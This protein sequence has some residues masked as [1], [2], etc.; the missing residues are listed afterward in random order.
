MKLLLNIY[1]LIFVFHCGTLFSLAKII[2]TKYGKI[3]GIKKNFYD[4]SVYEYLGVPFAKPPIGGLRFRT[5]VPLDEPAWTGV[6]KADKP[7]NACI[8]PIVKRG[9][10]GVG[11]IIEEEKQSEDC[12]QLNMWVPENPKGNVLVFIFGGSFRYGSPS[13]DIYNGSMIAYKTKQ[14]VVALNYRL[15]VL[16]FGYMCCGT[17]M[18]GNMGLL[19]QQLGLKWVYEN[20]KHFGGSNKQITLWGQGA[21]SVSASAHLFSDESSK[22][23]RRIILSSGTIFNN[24]GTTVRTSID[25]IIREIGIKFNCI[26]Q[27]NKIYKCLLSKDARD[28]M[29]AYEERIAHINV[30]YGRYGIGIITNDTVFFKGDVNDKIK[31]K[32]M[33]YSVDI[34]IG[35]TSNEA[36][37]FMPILRD[38]NKYGCEKTLTEPVKFTEKTCHLKSKKHLEM[39]IDSL[40]YPL[41]WN[42]SVVNVVKKTYM[43][44]G[45]KINYRN[46]ATALLSDVSFNCEIVNFASFCS[47]FS[48]GRIYFYRF[49]IKS[50]YH[51][52][53]D[54]MNT[55]HGL[56]LEY[57]FGLPFRYGEKYNKNSLTK[58]KMFSKYFMDII[59]K[60][61]L[62]GSTGSLW[63]QFTINRR[64][65]GILDFK[66]K[67][68][69]PVGH[70]S[71]INT[72]NCKT[73]GKYIPRNL[74]TL[75]NHKVTEYLGIPYARPPIGSLRFK[76]P[77]PL[78][79]FAW[80]STFNAIRPATSC[81][82]N[83]E[84][85]GFEGYDI[86][87][88]R[89][90]ISEDCLQFN[91]WVP[92]RPS[93]D[94]IVFIHGGSFIMGSG[95][96]DIYNG[97]VLAVKTRAI[98]V[99][100]NY[101]LG[102]FGFLYLP[103]HGISGN[104][105]LKDQQLGLKWIFEN[106]RYFGGH[107]K[108]ITL[109]GQS[110]GATSVTA[111]LFA[112]SSTRYIRRVIASSGTIGNMWGA[113]S[114]R[115]VKHASTEFCSKIDCDIETT[116]DVLHCLQRKA[117][118]IVYQTAEGLD[119]SLS[120]PLTH[121]FTVI[122][123]DNVFFKGNVKEKIK[124][125]KM[126]NNIDLLIGKMRDESTIYMP[127]I[128]DD[129]VFGCQF[130]HVYDKNSEKNACKMNRQNFEE[131]V[132]YIAER[133]ELKEKQK[134]ILKYRYLR[135]KSSEY[136][137]KAS[138]MISDVAFDCDIISFA[139]N[140][141]KI[142]KGKIFFYDINVIPSSSPWPSWMGATHTVD[143]KYAFGDPFR[144]PKSYNSTMLKKER[145]L[146]EN[147]MH[148]IG[149][150]VSTGLR[151]K[152]F[153]KFSYK[154]KVANIITRG[155][156][157]SGVY[158]F[159]PNIY[160]KNCE[161]IQGFLPKRIA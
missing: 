155:L 87:I 88:P 19:D 136:R 72:N 2:D 111:H 5:P 62:T 137:D 80:K 40:I 140:A 71:D 51:K 30:P 109:Y 74:R 92:E 43:P 37:F 104:M 6:F 54:W 152:R 16:G 50:S 105:G 17:D 103:D 121:P 84:R 82:Q 44:R 22:Y 32:Y 53:P 59:D 158:R 113:Q 9:F 142:L 129:D 69:G 110:S 75:L 161:A 47:L 120:L 151:N 15:G 93:G 4:D 73:I 36:A 13:L 157:R 67:A 160:S 7:A 57:G 159:H 101:R 127:Q 154:K 49:N 144:H 153:K 10:E 23:F 99:N 149:D 26:G 56:E 34:I 124:K 78:R 119:D 21:G 11:P 117:S 39:L 133:L 118:D 33:K 1:L 55:I 12:L 52:Y 28:I 42:S 128:F 97:S 46:Q 63:R 95:S 25:N 108:K 81:M 20:I 77:I 132:D 96:L 3:K 131:V 156:K 122:E 45:K 68:R 79:K 107:P 100:L 112:P 141:S 114:T 64:M 115:F 60:F 146:S 41:S 18:T 123:N 102:V 27:H 94:V 150:F 66:M 35:R 89:G 24:W 148:V 147:F 138:R 48:Y 86:M 91:M 145:E 143:I 31:R 70:V 38:S 98:V 65:A 58:E 139:I 90:K 83:H 135:Y 126:Q 125:K 116:T 8:Q 29:N 76:N 106:I 130:N 134:N 61:S 85:F 14:I